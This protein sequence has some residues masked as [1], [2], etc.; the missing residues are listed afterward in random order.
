MGYDRYNVDLVGDYAG[1]EFFLVDGNALLRHA[2]SNPRLD[3]SQG[4]QLL[5]AVYL[6]ERFLSACTHRRCNFSVVFL[7]EFKQSCVP[8]LAQSERYLLAREVVIKHLLNMPGG[9]DLAQVFPTFDDLHFRAYLDRTRPLFIMCH[10]EHH[11]DRNGTSSSDGDVSQS[12][13][14]DRCSERWMNLGFNLA[15][16]DTVE[17]RENKHFTIK[18]DDLH[19]PNQYPHTP[20]EGF[21]LHIPLQ[22]ARDTLSVTVV[23]HLLRHQPSQEIID[24]ARVFLLHTALQSTILFSH[25]RLQ[26]INSPP[27]AA[28]AFL[29]EVVLTSTRFLTSPH[30]S[31]KDKTN[32]IAD[33]VDGTLF[34]NLFYDDLSLLPGTSTKF[35]ELAKAVHAI[36]QI[37]LD[38]PSNVSLVEDSDPSLP[39]IRGNS[40]SSDF[41]QLL[42]FQNVIFDP[43]LQDVKIPSDVL[44]SLKPSDDSKAVYRERYHWHNSNKPLI[45]KAPRTPGRKPVHRTG[46]GNQGMT[47]YEKRL[48]GRAHKS[49][50][51]Y[52]SIMY[53]YAA[54]LTGSVDGALDARTI[55]VE[56][57]PPPKEK[58]SGKKVADKQKAAGPSKK[59][60]PGSKSADVIRQEN[61]AKKAEAVT[62]K[63][64][65]A[66]TTFCQNPGGNDERMLD[67]LDDWM[68]KNKPRGSLDAAALDAWHFIEVEARLYKVR[69][70]QRIWAGLIY[71]GKRESGYPCVAQ[72]FDEMKKILKSPGLTRKVYKIIRGVFKGL[73]IEIPPVSSPDSLPKQKINGVFGDWDGSSGLSTQLDTSSEEFQLMHC[74]PLMDRDMDSAPDSRVPFEPDGWQRKVLDEIDRNNSIFVVAPTSAGKTF[75]AFYAMEKVLKADDE[76]VLV[77]VAPT[78]AL[79]NQIAA[80]VISRFSKSYKHPGKT[81]WAIH[82]RDY[83]VNNPTTCQILVTVPHILQIMLLSPSNATTWAP[84]V[85]RI[86]F[87]EVH[88]IGNADDGLVWEQLLLMAPC[89]IIAL[90]ATVG[91]PDEFSAWLDT[92]QGSQ[93]TGFKAIYHPHRYSDLR[94]YIYVSRPLKKSTVAL[95]T[96]VPKFASLETCPDAKYIHPLISVNV[97]TQELPPDLTFEARD[98]LL[99]YHAMREAANAEWPLDE[100]VD[101]DA[102]FGTE[103]RVIKKVDIVKW[104]VSLKRQ[105]HTWLQDRNSPFRKVVEILK[106]HQGASGTY[107]PLKLKPDESAEAHLHETILPLLQSLHSSNALPAIVFQ[108]NRAVCERLCHTL[109]RQLSTAEARFKS[110]DAAFLRRVDELERRS[111]A[112]PQKVVHQ[113][114]GDKATAA[115]ESAEDRFDAANMFDPADYLAEYSFADFRKYTKEE[116]Q[117]DCAS[118]TRWGIPKDLVTALK[119][120]IGV[121]HSGMNRK[122]RQLVEMLFRKGFLRVIIATGTLAL[123]INMPTK[124][125]VFSGDSVFLTALNYRQAA[126]RAGRRGFDNLG[127]VVFHGISESQVFRLM[128]SKLPSLLGHF[129]I[130]VSLIL[131]SFILLHNSDDSEYAKRTI[132]SLLKQNR[133]ILGGSTYRHQVLHHLRFSI[134]FLR[135][136]HLLG[137]DGKPLNFAGMVTHLYYTENSALAL[138]ALLCSGDLQRLCE[139]VDEKP[140]TTCLQLMLIMAH[141][142]GRLPGTKN[143]K[144]LPGLPDDI[145][146]TLKKEN[147]DVVEVYTAYMQSYAQEHLTTP[148]DRMPL[149]SNQYG[150]SLPFPLSSPPVTIRSSFEALSGHGDTFSSPGELAST[151]R[152][153]LFIESA[154][155]PEFPIDPPGETCNSYLYDFYNH[156]D[157]HALWKDN[158]IRKADVWFK[159]KDF[160]LVIATIE[161]GLMCFI[162]DGPGAYY[163]FTPEEEDETEVIKVEEGEGEKEGGPVLKVDDEVASSDPTLDVA[164]DGGSATLGSDAEGSDADDLENMASSATSKSFVKVWKAFRLL[165]ADFNAKF[166]AMWA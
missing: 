127:N 48:A 69:L 142:F 100:S 98:C 140:G 24:F 46:K 111:R 51:V 17:I 126:G 107:K 35:S 63:L 123:G 28:V 160:S 86:I 57:S 39:V 122:Y 71:D 7:D 87:D 58:H 97:N 139:D 99:V 163:D 105:L 50:Q 109:C 121:H 30:A 135:R 146:A 91:N 147:Q 20:E 114:G 93:G 37:S 149:S 3:F 141:I 59:V 40:T 23:A 31:F 27:P 158:G 14:E 161:A 64:V 53:R 33:Y 83:R 129:P 138:H 32:D 90:S 19:E 153:G 13:G 66:W 25:R 67:Y 68:L 79:V 130:S 143:V 21:Q 96:Q 148:D 8:Q 10:Y 102:V 117:Q 42:P 74:G 157:T 2:F 72:L 104:E 164:S 49:N 89:P 16:I 77:Y 113:A 131:R 145:R 55:V 43:Y 1:S 101:L 34:F 115:R 52:L 76:G 61:Q 44:L 75:I 54:S 119:R 120:G 103:G 36:T 151:A 112:K 41:P 95:D 159:L 45:S 124:T 38:L 29:Q 88:S 26:P 106:A 56:D 166:E 22:S 152:D 5:H 47:S 62:Q 125:S 128:S 108:Y 116:L 12:P 9:Q 144:R 81:A 65:R 165:K 94:K 155:V 73:K 78:K 162:R 136:Q 4:F 84:K 60:K 110:T 18:L 6:V 118:L 92:T 134:E 82:T 132:D 11:P 150:G 154:V 156:G 85:K 80:E 70:L 137:A 15:L 133:L